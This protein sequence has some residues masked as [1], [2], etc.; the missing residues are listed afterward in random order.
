MEAVSEGRRMAAV[1]TAVLV[2]LEL[3]RLRRDA[4][5]IA[6]L[7]AVFAAPLF[8]PLAGGSA[9]RTQML[10]ALFLPVIIGWT[11][12]NDLASGRLV[13][14]ALSRFSP[15]RLMAA[16]I[17]AFGGIA[18]LASVGAAIASHAAVDEAGVLILFVL[19]LTV[20]A[21][22]LITALRSA[23]AG[24][25]PLFVAFAGVWLPMLAIMKRSGGAMPQR[26]L[27]WLTA[28]LLPQFAMELEFYLAR[29]L[30]LIYAVLAAAWSLLAWLA[31]SRP[32]ALERRTH[33]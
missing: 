7:A 5:A 17:A 30:M 1:A 29:Q 31:V 8:A 15:A 26:W 16:R 33:D 18:L 4:R 24:W 11:W 2:R 23:E 14:L 3:V 27:H 19:Q 32:E 21:F 13:P 10:T 6:A 9:V 12:G 22:A 25:I 28:M 20:F